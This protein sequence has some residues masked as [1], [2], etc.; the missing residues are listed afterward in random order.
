MR[1]LTAP[2]KELGEFEEIKMKLKGDHFC[3]SLTGCVESQKLH[4]A[5]GLGEGFKNKLI[6]TFSDLRVKE[7]IEDY[8][9]YDRNVTAYPAKD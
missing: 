8:R 4:M 9:L 5:Y 6:I 7:I 2:L 3:A 1:A